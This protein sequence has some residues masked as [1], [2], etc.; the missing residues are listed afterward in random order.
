MIEVEANHSQLFGLARHQGYV[1]GTCTAFTISDLHGVVHGAGELSVEYLCHFA[2]KHSTDWMPGYGFTVTGALAAAKMP[3]QPTEASFPYDPD[4]VDRPL[5]AVPA[6]L[7][8]LYTS[9]T[10]NRYLDTQ[11]VI[12]KLR[13]G[14]PVGIVIGVSKS[15]YAPQNGVIDFDPMA[16]PDLYHALIAVGLGRHKSTGETH[17]LLRNSWGTEWGNNGYAWISKPHLDVHLQEGF[18]I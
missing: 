11:E 12:D 17:V 2:A 6:N 13:F 1:R 3:G 7:A 9:N 5:K 14:T 8:P 18:V 4:D 15:L 10:R 16:I